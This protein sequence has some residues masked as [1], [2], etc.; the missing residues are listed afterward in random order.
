MNDVMRIIR[1][2]GYIQ[3][4][5]GKITL[6]GKE[7]LCVALDGYCTFASDSEKDDALELNDLQLDDIYN[8][9]YGFAPSQQAPTPEPKILA[10]RWFRPRSDTI[11]LVAIE[12]SQN[13]WE[14]HIGTA[15][16]HDVVFDEKFVAKWGAALSAEEAHGFFPHLDNS[17]Y[18][19]EK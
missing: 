6:F 7:V 4:G 9:T 2:N 13:E 16:G 17:K 8:Q 14:A 1:I 11:G 15:A 10:S 3:G 19:K 12:T 5:L 18:K